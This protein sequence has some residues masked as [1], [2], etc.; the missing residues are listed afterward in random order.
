MLDGSDDADRV[1]LWEND[2]QFKKVRKISI[3]DFLIP[4]I[5]QYH[6]NI[7][8]SHYHIVIIACCGASG[9]SHP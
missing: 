7:T 4:N 5:M 8:L 1:L 9:D 6:D 3:Y 2:L